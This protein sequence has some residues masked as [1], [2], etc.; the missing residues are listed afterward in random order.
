MK[1]KL[2]KAY[3]HGTKHW[4]AGAE[5][6]VTNELAAKMKQAG[7]LDKPKPKAAPK[8]DEDNNSEEE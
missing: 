3:K 4:K 1:V 8:K 6:T 5:P 2:Y 7:V